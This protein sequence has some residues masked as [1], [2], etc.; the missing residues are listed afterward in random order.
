MIAHPS[1]RHPLGRRLLAAGLAPLL[2]AG[3]T[4]L[5]G[6][7][8]EPNAYVA[9]AGQQKALAL[10]EDASGETCQ[11]QAAASGGAYVYCG[12][13]SQ[14]SGRVR[15]SGAG[16]PNEIMGLAT[17]GTWRTGLD[18]RF[19]CA[20]PTS[21]SILGN[22]P[23]ALLQCTQR[24]GGW[25][26]VALVASVDGKVWYADGVLPAL[27][28]MERS[29]GVL[30][31]RIKAE[32]AAQAEG[33]AADRLA[34]E[35][36][37]ARAF[38]SG[39]YG[40]YES[41][42]VAADN[43]NRAEDFVGAEKALRTALELQQKA[44]PPGPGGGD[45]PNI[46]GTLISLALQVSNQ[47]RDAE[48]E[49]L[50][51]RAERLVGSA[52][53]ETQSVRL[54]HYRGLA[55]LNQGQYE[56]AIT[57]LRQAANGYTALLP[58]EILNAHPQPRT[59]GSG[60]FGTSRLSD[61]LPGPDTLT[62]PTTRTALLGLIEVRRQEAVVLR[63]LNRLAE[64]DAALHAAED[65]ARG[66]ALRL[67]VIDARLTRTA[68][69]LTAERGDFSDAASEFSRAAT[70]FATALPDSRPV[71]VTELLLAADL[72]RSGKAADAAGVCHT[73]TGQLRK[74]QVGIDAKLL[75][76]CLDAFYAASQA[77]PDSGQQQFAEMF[78][79]TQLVQGGITSQQIAQATARLAENKRDPRVA[80]A[81]RAREKVVAELEDLA[82]QRNQI[83]ETTE[84]GQT[85]AI[86]A[87][88]APELDKKIEAAQRAL[89][90]AD[91]TMQAASP[92]YGQLVQTVAAAKDVLGLL[93]PNE[94]FVQISLT[95][96]GGWTFVLHNGAVHVAKVKGGTVRMAELVGKVRASI[97]PDAPTL[98]T[99][100]VAAAQEIYADTIAP[101]EADLAG[102][103]SLVIVPD[104]PLLSLP[105]EVLLT[106]PADA[107][108][109]GAAPWLLKRFTIAHVPAAAN[110]VSLRKIAGGSR[111]TRAWFG[112][113]D[114]RPVTLAQA[115]RTFGPG[116]ADAARLYAGLPLL[117]GTR[118][119][120]DAA[121]SLFAGAGTDIELGDAFTVDAVRK[122]DLKDYRILHFAAHAL[123]PAELRCESEPAIVTSPPP[124]AKDASGT[125][126]TSSIVLDLNLDADA[127]I[128]SACNSGGP[129]GKTAGES[130]SGLARAFFYA[131]ARSLMVTHWE[132]NDQIAAFLVADTLRRLREGKSGGIAGALRAAQLGLIADA[133]HGGVP[134]EVVHPSYWAPFAVIG[135]GTNRK[136]S[137]DSGI[138]M[139]HLAGL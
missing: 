57:L 109:L 59:M 69:A 50:F 101:L 8:T 110:F 51:Q 38:S 106:G 23:A 64:S 139:R 1:P 56:Q 129:G 35:R 26:H 7:A 28:V 113:G 88:L 117:P 58:S 78:E 55:A 104:G 27:P 24:V 86:N 21:T 133:G 48:A 112:F 74:L 92:N 13:W 49:G 80:D 93:A 43:A 39:D 9:G 135:E 32:S 10:G 95:D 98:P 118:R 25:A 14:P 17:A 40:E 52:A 89:A 11:Q 62:T 73:A 96:D 136:V 54:L 134:A 128:L 6:C 71:A 20:A 119:E 126:L 138:P 33:G 130:L 94:A 42:I 105:F 30:S 81:I 68:A 36:L 111:A 76:P 67:P 100:D 15:S 2:V 123:L 61:V 97:D 45:N 99:F 82:R 5:A 122:A 53:D 114:F 3:L 4:L 63:R 120:L 87:A 70:V 66:N 107:A 102:A 60:G 18:Q 91:S 72:V 19:N 125:L 124:G 31:G 12:A 121:R 137:A 47:H 79:A 84:P 83:A 108:N 115:E 75:A 37:A 22:N 103:D 90:D 29:I 44:L 41:L 34:A 132:V 131:G 85:N 77:S 46:A 116:C 127:V 65:L 16:G